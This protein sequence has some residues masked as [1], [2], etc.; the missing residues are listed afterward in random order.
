MQLVRHG[1][2]AIEIE[3]TR[4]E[5]AIDLWVTKDEP[6]VCVKVWLQKSGRLS[7]I[8]RRGKLLPYTIP[9]YLEYYG[10]YYPSGRR[11][12]QETQFTTAE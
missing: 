9:E 1:H 7:R 5:Q 4:Q 8:S 10:E 11:N 6:T 12:L 3:L 2:S